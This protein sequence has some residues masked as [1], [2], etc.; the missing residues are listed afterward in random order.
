MAKN[1]LDWIALI[2]VIVGAV[3]WGLAIWEWNLVDMLLGTWPIAVNVVYALIGL[4]GLY[5]IYLA[6]KE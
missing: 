1:W 6:F 5:T 2:L 3:N 4:A